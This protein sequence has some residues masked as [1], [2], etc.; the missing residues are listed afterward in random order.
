MIKVLVTGEHDTS[1]YPQKLPDGRPIQWTC[2]RVLRFERMPVNK[3]LVESVV[4]NPLDWI[5]FTSE[6]SVRFW[7]EL[8]LEYGFDFPIQTQV[9]C[10]GEATSQ[11]AEDD[12][13]T[14]DFYPT[15]PGSQG[16]LT[17]FEDLLSNS[18]AKPSVLIPMAQEGRTVIPD[19]LKSL[20]CKTEVLCLYRTIPLESIDLKPEVL[21][22]QDAVLVTSPSSVDSLWSRFSPSKKIKIISL[23]KHT[24]QRLGQ[25]GIPHST[26]PESQIDLVGEVLC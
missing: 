20:G 8:L 22:E 9:A 2:V 10:V 17:E 13:F 11:A 21:E 4:Q 19:R 6:R 12:G 23:G 3:E 14:C 7:S 18:S 25:L 26:L 5:I 24:S 16:F 1:S 15:E